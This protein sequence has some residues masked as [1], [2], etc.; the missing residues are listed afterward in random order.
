MAEGNR[1]VI[2]GTIVGRVTVLWI[3]LAAVFVVGAC[4]A[5]G[6]SRAPQGESTEARSTPFTRLELLPTSDSGVNGNA[7]LTSVATG[8]KVELRLRG[9]PEPGETYLP[10]ST[11][12]PAETSNMPTSAKGKLRIST[13]TDTSTGNKLVR[14]SIL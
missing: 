13:A 7:T 11:R 10:T 12:A 2:K 4:G 9:L 6:A 1:A 8:T 5:G 3:S 14:S